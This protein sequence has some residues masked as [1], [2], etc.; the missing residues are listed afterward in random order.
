[1]KISTLITFIAVILIFGIT[2]FAI[3]K[4]ETDKKIPNTP[5]NTNMPANTN[6]NQNT[7]SYRENPNSE[8]PAPTPPSQQSETYNVEIKNSLY[9]PKVLTIKNGDTVIWTNY[10]KT[11]THTITST[12]GKELSSKFL[13]YGENYTHTFNKEGKFFYYCIAHTSA[14]GE[15]I[16]E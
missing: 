2:L 14:H 16:V 5:D 10:D 4:T 6:E 1:M 8:Q 11:T 9:S 7:A 13:K 3:L 15:I 12:S